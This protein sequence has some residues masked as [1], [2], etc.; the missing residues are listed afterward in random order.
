MLQAGIMMAGIITEAPR[1]ISTGEDIITGI[2]STED[3]SSQIIMATISTMTGNV[4]INAGDDSYKTGRN[5]TSKS[6]LNF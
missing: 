4:I 1:V 6:G 3:M 2:I 5:Y